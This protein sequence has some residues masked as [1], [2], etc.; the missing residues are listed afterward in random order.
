[1]VHLT[2]PPKRTGDRIIYITGV[3]SSIPFFFVMTKVITGIGSRK[4]PPDICDMMTEVGRYIFSRD[5][6]CRSGHADGAD[7]AFEKGA[8]DRCIVYLPWERF[9]Y[10]VAPMLGVPYVLPNPIPQWCIDSLEAIGVNTSSLQDTT[11][12][13]FARNC[14]QLLGSTGNKP[15][16]AVVVWT[17]NGTATGGSGIAM[18]L[19]YKYGIPVYNMY[20]HKSTQRVIE[21]LEGLQ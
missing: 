18:K 21:F 2:F 4:T 10:P 13:L 3:G 20:H 11:L 1:M 15:S 17:Q 6:W 12:K 8:I 19:A 14:M 7:Y 16:N 9:R 5:W